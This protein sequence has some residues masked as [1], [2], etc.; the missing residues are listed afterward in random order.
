[1]EF[2]KGDG[3]MDKKIEDLQKYIHMDSWLNEKSGNVVKYLS[4]LSESIQNNKELIPKE[5]YE[6]ISNYVFISL[7]DATK[8]YGFI[9]DSEEQSGREGELIFDKGREGLE[10]VLVKFGQL[11][12]TS[13]QKKNEDLEEVIVN[14]EEAIKGDRTNRTLVHSTLANYQ[15]RLT[16]VKEQID[17]LENSIEKVTFAELDWESFVLTAKFI[18][19]DLK[20]EL[21]KSRE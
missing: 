18:I 6:D 10:Q 21:E 4:W 14:L 12:K 7:I 9:C 19:D 8:V 17:K 11:E 13:K 5:I 1:M 15:N 2:C 20:M 16:S 3:E